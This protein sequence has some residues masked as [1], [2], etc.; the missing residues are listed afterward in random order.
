VVRIDEENNVPFY[1]STGLGGKD[2]ELYPAGKWYPFWGY[3]N[4]AQFF[5]KDEG[6]QN[7]YEIP[8]LEQISRQLDEIT[9]GLPKLRGKSWRSVRSLEDGSMNDDFRNLINNTAYLNA[10]KIMS[11]RDVKNHINV[12]KKK[13]RDL[14]RS[15][16]K[17]KSEDFPAERLSSGDIKKPSYPREP[18]LGAFLGDAEKRFEGVTSWEEFKERYNDTEMVFLDYETTG[19]NF[20]D[21]GEKLKQQMSFLCGLLN[22]VNNF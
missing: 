6:M 1:R 19:L 8:E 2:Q 4:S 16:N 3:S 21:F 22:S 5:I 12:S 20:D 11:D 18:T 14:I 17:R 13:L 15:R 10:D 7:Y 9:E